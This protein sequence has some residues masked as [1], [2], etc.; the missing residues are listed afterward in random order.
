MRGGQ[1]ELADLPGSAVASGNPTL[2]FFSRPKFTVACLVGKAANDRRVGGERGTSSP[3]QGHR[4]CHTLSPGPGMREEPSLP[5][6]GHW[7]HR[8]A[9]FPSRA[10]DR[11]EGGGGEG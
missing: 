9:S 11:P 5:P 3:S 8:S 4:W 10:A 7:N 2:L 1:A 6:P